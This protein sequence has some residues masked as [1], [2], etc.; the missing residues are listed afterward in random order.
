[1]LVSIGLTPAIDDHPGR[2]SHKAYSFSA[3]SPFSLV[4]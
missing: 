3:S 1:M 4:L 2:S